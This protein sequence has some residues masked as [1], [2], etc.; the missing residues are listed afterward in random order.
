MNVYSDKECHNICLE[1]FA[2]NIEDNDYKSMS[3]SM[4]LAVAIL[5]GVNFSDLASREWRGLGTG[6]RLRDVASDLPTRY[7]LSN[8][9]ASSSWPEATRAHTP[10]FCSDDMRLQQTKSRI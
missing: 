2:M 4:S 7:T 3:M 10:E 9:S 8:R 1:P 6:V 5:L